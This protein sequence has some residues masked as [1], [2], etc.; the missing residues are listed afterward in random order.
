VVALV[1]SSI[2]SKVLLCWR[3]L[4]RLGIIPKD[5]PRARASVVNAS[6]VVIDGHTKGESVETEG[7]KDAVAQMMEEF[8]SE[9]G[10]LQPMK[11]EPMTIHIQ[12]DV[13]IKPLCICTPMK[14]P[15]AY[16]DAAKA[17]LDEDEAK[18]S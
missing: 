15:Y 1:S 16:Q 10:Q 3:T 11:R 6:P 12:K 8:F 4:K 7:V 2:K 18:G 14:T 5:F 13:D 17:K 9:E